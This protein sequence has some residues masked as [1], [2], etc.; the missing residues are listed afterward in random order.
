MSWRSVCIDWCSNIHV[1]LSAL[2]WTIWII[3]VI[4]MIWWKNSIMIRVTLCETRIYSP[5]CSILLIVVCSRCIC[6]F[7]WL[8]TYASQSS[9]P[10]ASFIWIQCIIVMRCIVFGILIIIVVVACI[11][12]CICTISGIY[13]V[14]ICISYWT[15]S[16]VNVLVWT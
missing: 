2:I 13:I 15:S 16:L 12:I 4:W 14:V 6:L 5:C 7:S 11:N 8:R 3:W 10:G 9:N 1:I